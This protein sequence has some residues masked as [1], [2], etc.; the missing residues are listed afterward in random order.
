MLNDTIIKAFRFAEYHH[1]NQ[2]DKA[3]EPYINHL[4]RVAARVS[5]VTTDRSETA[6]ALLHDV[7][8]DTDVTVE[9]VRELFGDTIADAVDAIT[10]RKHETVQNYLYRVSQ[11]KIALRVKLCDIAD[12]KDEDRLKKLSKEE[13][14][15]LKNKYA[16][17]LNIFVQ[18]QYQG[19]I[20]EY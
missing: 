6:V 18:M 20:K 14:K 17:Y 19:L 16:K 11:N 12:N 2:K 5:P 7:V 4:I 1:R 8:E 3:G 13:A 10:K 15:R 9:Q